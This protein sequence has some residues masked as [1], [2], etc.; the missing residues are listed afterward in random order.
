MRPQA[1]ARDQNEGL[2]LRDYN[3]ALHQHNLAS[4]L[5]LVVP[6]NRA[7]A[8]MQPRKRT[9]RHCRRQKLH[10]CAFFWGGVMLPYMCGIYGDIQVDLCVGVCGWLGVVWVCGCVV[11]ACVCVVCVVSLQP[12]ASGGEF[13]FV[14]H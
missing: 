2:H 6:E 12:S 10:A 1:T 11:C 7:R 8:C 9:H 3:C 5:E 14:I 13:F 4:G